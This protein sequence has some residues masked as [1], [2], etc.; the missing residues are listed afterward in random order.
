[1]NLDL[2]VKDNFLPKDLFQK[3]SIYCTTLDYGKEI[4]YNKI[5]HVF[6]S[7]KIHENDDLLKDL[8]KSIIK[9]FK[10]GIKNLHLASFTLVNTKE[11]LP[12]TDA[13]QFPTEKHLIIYLSGDSNL[14]AGTG[15]YKPTDDGF[16]LNTAI[17]CYPNR[18]VLF[19]AS[20]CHHSPLLYTAKNSIPRFAIIIWFE[21]K[22]DL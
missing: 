15:F 8:E 21:P 18:A 14:N 3:L 1:M 11:P 12:H 2:Q 13:L 22:I 7:N 9:H 10:V 17:G 5:G 16:D 4:T 19:N 6:Y 20:D